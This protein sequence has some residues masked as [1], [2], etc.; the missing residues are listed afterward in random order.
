M[1]K[2]NTFKVTRPE[3]LAAAKEFRDSRERMHQ[4]FAAL[5]KKQELELERFTTEYRNH[6]RNL[7]RTIT[8]GIVE[9]PD[10]A[11]MKE[12][13]IVEVRFIDHGEAYVIEIPKENSEQPQAPENL[14][15]P[16]RIITKH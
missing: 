2:I 9:F 7:F 12:T 8:T 14:P 11:Y 10:E 1:T 4:E 15:G 3:A 5:Q 13:H 16:S 6:F